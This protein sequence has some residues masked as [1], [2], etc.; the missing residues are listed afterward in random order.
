M[1]HDGT[2]AATRDTR[3][4]VRIAGGVLA[5]AFVGVSALSQVP[6]PGRVV[7][8]VPITSE[9][10]DTMAAF[11][12]RCVG[13]AVERGAEPVVFRIDTP[14]GMVTSLHALVAAMEKLEGVRTIAYVERCAWSAGALIALSAQEIYMSKGATI[15]SAEPVGIGI[16][17]PMRLGEK[18]VSAIRAEFEAK[19]AENGHDPLL[20]KAMVDKDLELLL[21]E[22]PDAESPKIMTREDYNIALEN[23]LQ[24]GRAARPRLVKTIVKEGKLLN[25]S[26]EP[27]A[28][29]GLSSGTVKDLAA[30]LERLGLAEAEIIQ[31]EFTWLESLVRFLTGPLVQSA[32][33]IIGI[34]AL[35]IEF[36]IPGFGVPGIVGVSCLAVLF[37]AKYLL[38]LANW[39]EILMFFVGLGL[40][41]IE[42]FVI[43]GFGFAGLSGIMLMLVS[44]VLMSL[45]FNPVSRELQ[46]WDYSHLVNTSVITFLSFAGGVFV[47]VIAM[48]VLSHLIPRTNIG[49]GLVQRG[50]LRPDHG[51]V[52]VASGLEEL[53]G[54]TG[55][56]LSLLRPAGRARFGEKVIDVVTQ[57]EFLPPGTE[58][59]VVEV[60]GNRVVVKKC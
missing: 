7:M 54:A 25:L 15:G 35:G 57:G 14:G 29:L 59:E 24:T 9:I 38:G 16:E 3:R 17:G 52:S 11:V 40:L 22:T 19:A 26:A 60:A 2:T 21:V 30:L 6:G 1:T 28:E 13:L 44:L 32:L 49:G 23:F 36:K 34:S 43:P 18:Y 56:A 51:F 55:A 20:A 37:F 48:S 53:R 41:G 8:V 12:D 33:L 46:P 39:I 27:A 45:K 10:D 31:P 5:L 58:V 42:I 47:L 4:L 50:E